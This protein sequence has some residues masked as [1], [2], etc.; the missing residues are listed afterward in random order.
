MS[1]PTEGSQVGMGAEANEPQPKAAPETEAEGKEAG[2]PRRKRVNRNPRLLRPV[3]GEQ[4]VEA[5]PPVRAIWERLGSL[6]RSRF[7]EPL[8][9]VEGGA[10]R[11][12]WDPHLRISLWV[13][14]SSEGVSSAREVE[15]RPRRRRKPPRGE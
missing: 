12:A 7:Q 13:Y 2:P 5:D 10:G 15:R 11:P 6:D 8:G 4:R 1:S 3:D 14:A 9:A